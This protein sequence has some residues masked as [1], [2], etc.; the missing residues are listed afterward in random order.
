[1]ESV[2]KKLFPLPE[3]VD[4]TMYINGIKPLNL[5]LENENWKIKVSV[6]LRPVF[7]IQWYLQGLIKSYY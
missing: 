7:K 3:S 1:M 5:I 2:F 6:Y 4:Y